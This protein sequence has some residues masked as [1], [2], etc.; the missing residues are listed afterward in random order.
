[1]NLRSWLASTEKKLTHA[2]PDT[3]K[4]TQNTLEQIFVK[5]ISA[6]A[7]YTPPGRAVRQLVAQCLIKVYRRG[8]TRTL[9]DTLQALM[10]IV[11]DFKAIEKDTVKVAA[12]SCIG[13]L[14]YE[15]GTQVMFFMAEISM[16]TLRM[17]KSSNRS[18]P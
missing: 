12:F 7:P 13:D 15:F 2:N 5:I 3:L 17:A 6:S 16:V 8:E 18:A 10:K 11:G 9:F 4:G 1:M 14:M